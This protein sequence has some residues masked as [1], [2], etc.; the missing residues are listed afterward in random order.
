MGFQGRLGNPNS[1]L[2]SF[3][4]GSVGLPSASPMALTVTLGSNLGICDGWG[5]S[6][7][8]AIPY[9][10]AVADF[11]FRADVGI[12]LTHCRE[13]ITVDGY[14]VTNTVDGNPAPGSAYA[15]DSSAI[16]ADDHAYGVAAQA[17]ARGAKVWG[18]MW[19]FPTAW[20]GGS[21]NG[22]LAVGHYTD[23]ANLLV[24]Y[25]SQAWALGIPIYYVGVCNE[26]DISPG[27]PQTSWTTS[28][29]IA[30]IKGNLFG[31]L[32]TWANS[33]PSWQAATGLLQPGIVAPQTSNWANLATWI[34]AIEADA[35]C[36]SEVALYGTHQYFGGGVSAPPATVSHNIW[37]TETVPNQGGAWDATMTHAQTTVAQ[38]YNAFVTGNAT[39]WHYWFGEDVSDTDNSGLVGTPATNWNNPALSL[40]D[41][42]API[43]PK[44]AYAFGQFS[45]WVRPGY[46]R[47]SATGAPSGIN[48][49][50]WQ[51][52]GTNRII[53][54]CINTNGSDT[55]MTIQFGG[56]GA[57]TGKL[58]PYVTDPTRNL[59]EQAPVA[60]S[61][62]TSVSVTV[63]ANSVTTY[64]FDPSVQLSRKF[65]AG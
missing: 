13:H 53:I 56:V 10:A 29:L 35:T 18:T 58:T 3:S 20:Q 22:A 4:L 17:N 38:I 44:R 60:M 9:S 37:E 48:A 59:L 24:A 5:A 36:V 30:F 7:A 19:A 2:G 65:L 64:I 27:Y 34:N 54:V 1:R 41:W 25:V 32:Q 14:P 31:A 12:G 39:N 55:A 40:A 6:S 63:P 50:A 26:P 49:L 45:K 42:N 62:T 15:M 51:K 28:Q 61:A 57:L 23:A 11:L 8:F 21:A 46:V 16:G 43:F 47:L 33:N 52:P